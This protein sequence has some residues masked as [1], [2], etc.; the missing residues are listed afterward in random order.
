MKYYVIETKQ[1]ANKVDKN[2]A[3]FD[4]LDAAEASYYKKRASAITTEAVL[5]QQLIVLNS[6]NGIHDQWSLDKTEEGLDNK[7]FVLVISDGDSSIQ[8]K[9]IYE[10]E[11]KELAEADYCQKYGTA[12]GSDLYTSCQAMYFDSHNNIYE[13][14][15]FQ[16]G[17]SEA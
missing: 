1:T 14:E 8:G 5:G 7:F 10:D 6:A 13:S 3:T 12:L 9:S 16:R 4:N 2:I 17:N 11:T 15:M